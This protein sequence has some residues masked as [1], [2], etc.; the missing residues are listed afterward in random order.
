V[1][2]EPIPHSPGLWQP[3]PVRQARADYTLEDLLALPPDAPR[4][5]LLDGVIHVTPS[6]T[7]GHQ[8]IASLV[9]AW[10]HR[11]AP[12]HLRAVQAVGVALAAN[13]SRQPDVILHRASVALSLSFLMPHDVVLAVEIVSPGTRRTDRFAKPGEYAA[14]GIPY[15]WRIEQ[16]P[17]H[18]YAYRLGDRPGPAGERQYELVSDSADAIELA[19]PFPM[20]LQIA[21]LTP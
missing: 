6:P 4:V 3:D 15:Y 13:T 8:N 5:E 10:L 17:I 21:D 20:T 19:E 16:D 12:A 7:L 2:A 1:S 11:H 14:A 18:L 9:W